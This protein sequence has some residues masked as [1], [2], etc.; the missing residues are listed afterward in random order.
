MAKVDAAK[1]LEFMRDSNPEVAKDAD[2]LIDGMIRPAAT[3]FESW[4]NCI[5]EID[6]FRR[7][8]KFDIAFRMLEQQLKAPSRPQCEFDQLFIKACA[9]DISAVAECLRTRSDD[10][11]KAL[12]HLYLIV[13]DRANK[14]SIVLLSKISEKLS[15]KREFEISVPGKYKTRNKLHFIE[16]VMG[17]IRTQQHPRIVFMVAMN[18]KRHKY[19]L[20]GLEDLRNDERLR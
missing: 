7:N 8:G 3:C 18:G 12:H 13:T 20:K 11:W 1:F 14:L 6:R 17:V 9:K 2:L 10:L 4:M 16:S 19:L 15:Q 5:E